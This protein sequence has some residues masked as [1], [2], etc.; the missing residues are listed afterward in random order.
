M[1][2][3]MGKSLR[4]LEEKKEIVKFVEEERKRDE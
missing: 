2:H 4:E 1:K 3:A